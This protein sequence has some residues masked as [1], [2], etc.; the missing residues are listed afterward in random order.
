MCL[1]FVKLYKPLGFILAYR[2]G[3]YFPNEKGVGEEGGEVKLSIIYNNNLTENLG[4]V[5]ISFRLPW[6]RGGC[7]ISDH[8][9]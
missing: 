6:G 1:L 3:G 7:K 2:H 5:G 4:A 9:L 8:P